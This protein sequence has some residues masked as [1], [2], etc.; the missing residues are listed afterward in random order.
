ME[1]KHSEYLQHIDQMVSDVQIE[2]NATK[3]T[4]F[5][6]F[7]L[8][9]CNL[10]LPV[11]YPGFTLI[12]PTFEHDK[13]NNVPF[14][15]L[16]EAQR[17]LKL[18][19][20]MKLA[21]AP[22]SAFHMTIARLISGDEYKNKLT[23]RKEALFLDT[24]H[25]LFNH[26]AF[27][28]TLTMEIKGLSVFPQGVIAAMVSPT[29][30]ETYSRLQ[31]FRNFIYGNEVLV[32]LGVER[33]R[34]FSGHITLAYIEDDLSSDEKTVLADLVTKINKI[35]FSKP[36]RYIINQAEIRKFNDFSRFYRDEHWPVYL[37]SRHR[38]S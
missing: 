25:K 14:L 28:G 17:F 15:R 5:G 11:S 19:N 2:E 30:E 31:H 16:C 20:S 4:P 10:W 7:K 24:F 36:L 26:S 27:S 32:S 6:K 1:K 18:F 23:V 35:C 22:T 13:E 33:K 12:T 29:S 3:I 8:N 21:P 37:F 38:K 34:S 9:P